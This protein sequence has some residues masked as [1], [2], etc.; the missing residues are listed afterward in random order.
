MLLLDSK[1]LV[2]PICVFLLFMLLCACGTPKSTVSSFRVNDGILEPAAFGVPVYK[3]TQARLK[4]V[5]RGE[6]AAL[7]FDE[8]SFSVGVADGV[9]GMLWS[10]LPLEGEIPAYTLSLTVA[11]KQGR[12]YL[13]SQDNAAAYGSVSYETMENGVL[14]TWIFSDQPASANKP[15]AALDRGELQV[16]VP[17]AFTLIDDN[18]VAEI[19]AGKILVSNGFYLETLSVLPY[20]G[21]F[22]YGTAEADRSSFVR[23]LFPGLQEDAVAAQNGNALSDDYILLPDGCGAVL[24]PGLAGDAYADLTYR[25]SPA[26]GEGIPPA[27]LGAFGIKKANGAFVCTVT[28]GLA[29]ADVRSVLVPNGNETARTAFAR[30]SMTQ[31]QTAD[32]RMYYGRPY[33]GR[34]RLE[35]R[36]L[37][38]YRTG[39]IAMADACRESLIRA[40]L[41]RERELAGSA[42][43]LQISLLCSEIGK[44]D[45]QTDFDKIGDLLALV[46]AKGVDAAQVVL[47]GMFPD[48][49]LQDLSTG[50]V[51]AKTL[52]GKRSFLTLCADAHKLGYEV[53]PCVNLLYGRERNAAKKL[54]GDYQY[55][56]TEFGD[57]AYLYQNEVSPPA[58]ALLSS[59]A[60]EKQAIRVLNRM[61]NLPVDGVCVNDVAKEHY[62]DPSA[63]RD[64]SAV[65]A[66]VNAQLSALSGAGKLIL[67]GENG[68]MLKDASGFLS[69]PFETNAPESE[70]FAAV[71]VLPAVLHGSVYY[72]GPAINATTL[73][74]LSFLKCVEYGAI[75]SV[76]WVYPSGE[77]LSYDRSLNQT[78]AWTKRVNAVLNDLYSLRIS[79]HS[80][81][82]AGVY[83]T[84]YENG[85]SVFVNYNNYSVNV[86]SIQIPPYD[87][88]RMN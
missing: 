9:S 44:A 87:F 82:S 23:G 86:N 31:T 37:S 53:F 25:V 66:E 17:V 73:P 70:A 5:A 19:D 4:T 36:F 74:T 32:G 52:G 78:T 35:Y 24:Y 18:L 40:G 3:N 7:L 81:V 8:Q 84:D 34:I 15:F 72:A 22:F 75:P 56:Y 58:T 67:S 62:A 76:S 65:C 54:N 63:G 46:K 85:A 10:A 13:N 2:R 1:R 12:Y 29:V 64:V 51:P 16:V 49:L 80:Q 83:R 48:G 45:A 59:K 50:L 39:Y 21:A 26:A 27:S 77:L 57:Y 55:V 28:D 47:W 41:F 33:G 88:L 14:V 68:G 79:G 38:G 42:V 20:F 61:K 11:A 30:F 71:P 6:S 43:P 69:L 60:V